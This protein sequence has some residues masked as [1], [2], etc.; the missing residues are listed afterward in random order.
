VNGS[1][2]VSGAGPSGRAG[3]IVQAFNAG[4]QTTQVVDASW[5]VDRGNGHSTFVEVV[6][7]GGIESPFT[8]PDKAL[9]TPLLRIELWLT[10]HQHLSVSYEQG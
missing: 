2:W 3:F 10:C 9:M 8:P 1:P 6:H 4:N 5:E 7:G